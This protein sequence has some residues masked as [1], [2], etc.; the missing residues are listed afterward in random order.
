MDSSNLVMNYLKLQAVSREQHLF[1]DLSVKC[2][3]IVIVIISLDP[4]RQWFFV[5]NS[6]LHSSAAVYRSSSST[7][8]H[9][10]MHPGGWLACLNSLFLFTKEIGARAAAWTGPVW[11]GLVLQNVLLLLAFSNWPW[12]KR[13]AGRHAGRREKMQCNQANGQ[14]GK[15]N[16]LC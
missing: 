7:W 15:E 8:T 12:R 1:L 4:T 3:L 14:A 5:I 10:R 11:A 16:A 13:P 2:Y 9:K 6:R